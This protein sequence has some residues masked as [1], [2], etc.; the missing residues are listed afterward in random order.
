ME[1]KS[2]E[3]AAE[4]LEACTGQGTQYP[5][6]TFTVTKAVDY[7]FQ[8][9]GG[10]VEGGLA[11]WVIFGDEEAP[12]TGLRHLQGYVQFVK[13]KRLTELAKILHG[14]V[15]HWEPAKG[16]P[17]ENFD[18]CSKTG[19]HQPEPPGESNVDRGKF[20]EFGERPE[21]ENAGEREKRR[22]EEAFGHAK[23][24]TLG[25]VDP[26]ILVCHYKSLKMIH[27]DFREKPAV[28]EYHGT[29][30]LQHRFRWYYGEPGCGKTKHCHDLA[31]ALGREVYAKAHNKWWCGY[32]P[33]DVVVMDDVNQ[34]AK[35]LGD[36]I[37]LWCQEYP[38][39]AETK[40][41]MATIR[42]DYIFFTSNYHPYDIFT[43]KAMRESIQRRMLIEF[44]G[45]DPTYI[46]VGP[47]ATVNDFVVPANQ[48]HAGAV[49]LAEA[50]KATP[51]RVRTTAIPPGAPVRPRLYRSV[52]Q[53]IDPSKPVEVHDLTGDDPEDEE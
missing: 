3:A 34:D 27:N 11:K 53:M 8:V 50:L 43:D 5:N 44:I 46:Y 13:R 36:F 48:Q 39:Q 23:A 37:K 15:C 28:A 14:S 4:Y 30:E 26:Q 18:Y 20:Y 17:S 21:F 40:G 9:M 6:W 19:K 1:H 22:W 41:G 31:R 25:H 51:A 45:K 33:G 10:L 29:V 2:S 35:W 42:P 32:K 38:F 24:G 49:P 12:T 52:T 7:G 47:K 16:T